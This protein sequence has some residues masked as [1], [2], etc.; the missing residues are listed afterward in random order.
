MSRHVMPQANSWKHL[1]S[2]N[3]ALVPCFLIH[4]VPFSRRDV[5]TLAHRALPR[6]RT[7]AP[8][9]LLCN[10]A[11]DCVV[12]AAFAAQFDLVITEGNSRS[13]DE[14]TLAQFVG[15]WWRRGVGYS[16]RD[17]ICSDWGRNIADAVFLRTVIPADCAALAR[18]FGCSREHLARELQRGGGGFTL[19]LLLDIAYV[20]ELFPRL[21]LGFTWRQIAHDLGTSVRT[22]RRSRH[23]VSA[24]LSQ[25]IRDFRTLQWALNGDTS[26]VTSQ[27]SSVS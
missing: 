2:R 3:A 17:S 20:A 24:V 23:R 9:I 12:S 6:L 26:L 7:I 1:P 22:L 14:Q 16:L 13:Q 11:D 15:A 8:T 21:G 4:L 18:S 10:D 19:K 27:R 5:S 25:D